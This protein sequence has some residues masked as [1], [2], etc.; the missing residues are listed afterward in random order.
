MQ[1]NAIVTLE[2]QDCDICVKVCR[3]G[4]TRLFSSGGK[5]QLF[6]NQPNPFNA[7]TVIRYELIEMGPTQIFVT[8]ILG[9]KIATLVDET[10][11]A[12]VYEARFDAMTLP[13]GLY[14]CILETPTVMKQRM[15]QV[16]K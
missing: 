16:I 11:D 7:Q 6:Q 14:F 5:V 15:M 9:R 8:D 2:N 4:G 1:G 10:K 3:S 12:G 13:S